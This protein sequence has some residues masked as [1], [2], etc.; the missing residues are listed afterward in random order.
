[1][2]IIKVCD[3]RAE[4]VCKG[5]RHWFERHGLDWRDYIRN[6]IDVERLRATGD[7]PDLIDRLEA[8]AKARE[9]SENGR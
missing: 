6:G 8:R 3:Q 1:M 2:T 7:I 9:A 5:A 4:G